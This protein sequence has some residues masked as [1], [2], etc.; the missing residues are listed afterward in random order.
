MG[1]KTQF[2][3][4]T[5]AHLFVPM[6]WKLIY[7]AIK[8]KFGKGELKAFKR[9]KDFITIG[10]RKPVYCSPLYHEMKDLGTILGVNVFQ[11]LY[12]NT[13]DKEQIEAYIKFENQK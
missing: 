12:R 5:F 1:M 11:Y 4:L 6:T 10:E 9:G 8:I 2:N 3:G 13:T 7:S